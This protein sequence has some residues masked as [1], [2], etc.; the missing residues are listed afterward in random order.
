MYHHR[1]MTNGIHVVIVRRTMASSSSLSSLS[2]S[3]PSS[4]GTKVVSGPTEKLK[5]WESGAKMIKDPKL[6]DN[7]QY[8][9]HIRAVHDPSLHVKTLEDELKG[10]I[11]E[12][13]GKQGHKILNALRLMEQERQ[14]YQELLLDGNDNDANAARRLV[15]IESAKQYNAHRQSCIQARWELIV[16]RQAVGF[17][18]GNHKYVMGKFPIGEPLPEDLNFSAEKTE[19]PV[20][21]PQNKKKF[22]DQLDWWERF[23]R[24]K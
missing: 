16:H 5:S 7:N 18:V 13:L 6:L 11:G 8:M 14:R 15:V 9:D 2:S 17:I 21:A 23:G 20:E 12:A 10:T 4:S 3:F 24:W 22:G 19:E 1:R